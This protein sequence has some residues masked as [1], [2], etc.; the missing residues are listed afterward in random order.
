MRNAFDRVCDGFL[1]G[2]GISLFFFTKRCVRRA[3]GFNGNGC[4]LCGF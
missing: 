3:L 1:I 4:I 2:F